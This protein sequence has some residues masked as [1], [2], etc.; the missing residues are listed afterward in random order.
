MKLIQYLKENDLTDEEFATRV[1]GAATSGSVR[2]W[3]YG[4]RAPRLPELV[5]IE[6]V[7]N[8]AVAARDFL[9][10]Q[11]PAPIPGESSEVLTSPEPQAEPPFTPEAA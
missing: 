8:G 6:E 5:R 4:E 11:E 2:K 1:G 10:E 9:P 3:K 7:T